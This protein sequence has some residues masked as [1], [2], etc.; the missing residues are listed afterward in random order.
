MSIPRPMKAHSSRSDAPASRR[1]RYTSSN[2]RRDSA[3]M[4][5]SAVAAE[6]ACAHTSSA[7]GF[8]RTS[9]R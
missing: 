1:V 9:S 7:D 6:K 2:W 4:A 5:G 3:P 8:D